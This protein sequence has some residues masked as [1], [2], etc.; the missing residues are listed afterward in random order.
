MVSLMHRARV[1]TFLSLLLLSGLSACGGS[2]GNLAVD[3]DIDGYG[4]SLQT[5]FAWFDQTQAAS[6]DG[7]VV[8]EE[9]GLADLHVVLSGAAF[10]PNQDL[11][12]LSQSEAERIVREAVQNGSVRLT[13]KDYKNLTTG[14]A[15]TLPEPT[16]S[17]APGWNL[18]YQFAPL[19]LDADARFPEAPPVY[20]SNTQWSLTLNEI[21]PEVGGNITGTLQGTFARG[22]TDPSD[23]RIGTIMVDFTAPVLSERL[24]ECNASIDIRDPQTFWARPC[25]LNFNLAGE[26][27]NGGL[28]DNAQDF[29][30]F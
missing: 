5:A 2:F 27:E 4:L 7:R 9:R 6:A 25:D 14:T 3:G 11:R 26:L 17:G 18:T 12:F 21:D 30:D 8:Y 13:V 23:A 10:E 15:L 16:T 28:P 19:E 24:A 29:E 22:E 1:A 20:G